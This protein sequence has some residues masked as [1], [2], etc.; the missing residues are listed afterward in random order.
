MEFDRLYGWEMTL[1]EPT[2]FWDKVPPRWKYDYSFFNAPVSKDLSSAHHPLQVMRA[3]GVKE[4]DFVAFK[5]DIDTPSVEI[6][7]VL[8]LNTTSEFFSLV[9]EF[10]FELHYRCE[11]FE[12]IWGTPP[13]YIE[14][15]ATTRAAALRLFSDLRHKGIRAHFWP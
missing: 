2:D 4:S 7:L 6:P 10:F 13:D 14:G 9:D 3:I 5:L 1:L 12:K 11:V 8:Q 15:L